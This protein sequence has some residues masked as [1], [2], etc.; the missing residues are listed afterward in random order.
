MRYLLDTNVL[1]RLV[2]RP[3]DLLRKIAAV[4]ADA[5]VT[6]I[7][8]AAELRFGALKKRSDELT[9]RVD[10]LL[11]AL[12]VLPLEGGVDRTYA[13]VRARLETIGRPIGSNDYWIAAHALAADCTLVTDNVQGF[14]RVPNLRVENWLR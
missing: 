12:T 6:S 8:V 4:G 7:V 2:R 13:A 14:R 1:S 9:T 10:E 3:E 11:E 5:V